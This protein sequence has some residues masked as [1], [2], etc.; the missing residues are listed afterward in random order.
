LIGRLALL[1]LHMTAQVVL[2]SLGLTLGMCLISAAI[3]VRRV[4]T[5]DP[6]EVF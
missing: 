4:I 2:V 1:P 3:A 5:A 6:A